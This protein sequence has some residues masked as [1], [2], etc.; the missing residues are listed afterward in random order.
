MLGL[1]SFSLSFLFPEEKNCDDDDHDTDVS[2]QIGE[3]REKCSQ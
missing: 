2:G 3:R 1:Y